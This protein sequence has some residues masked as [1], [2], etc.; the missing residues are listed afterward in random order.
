MHIIE[1]TLYHYLIVAAI[2]FFVGFYGLL[3]SKNLIRVL[4]CI[5]LLLNSVNINLVAFS[6]YID[7]N[8]IK[9]HVFSIFVMT[10]AAAEAAI[11]FAIILAVY[12]NR[13]TIEV[14]KFDILKW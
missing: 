12:R 5:E 6:N 7:P 14:D 3:T 2:I 10:V 4:L 11:A 9:G 13:H 1:P 8:L